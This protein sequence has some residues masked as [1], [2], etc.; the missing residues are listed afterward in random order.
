MANSLTSIDPS[1]LS[2]D[3]SNL[4]TLNSKIK[5]DNNKEGKSFKELL[6]EKFNPD[7]TVNELKL[8]KREKKLHDS[9]IDLESLLW[10]QVLKEMKKTI[11][12]YKLIDGGQAEEIFSDFLY[13][14]YATMIAKNSSTRIS[15]ELFK[16][17]SGYK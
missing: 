6:K 10:K 17:L 13:D 15:D 9:C 5:N 16:Q 3:L 7:G 12:K 2:Q 8:D 1:F 11:N 14:E 4:N